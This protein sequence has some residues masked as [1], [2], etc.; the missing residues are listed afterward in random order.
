MINNYNHHSGLSSRRGKNLGSYRRGQSFWR[1]LTSERER[2]FEKEDIAHWDSRDAE[3][4]ES[5]SGSSSNNNKSH[6]KYGGDRGSDR[7][8]FLSSSFHI[9]L[10][11]S[12]L[13]S[14][15]ATEEGKTF[16]IR[17]CQRWQKSQNLSW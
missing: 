9:R 5:R 13:R 11:Q 2:P 15:F 6:S 1:T 17:L 4:D 3:A 12:S 14:S 16:T 8:V 10:K 7:E